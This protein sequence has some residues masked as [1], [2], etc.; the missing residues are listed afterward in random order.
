M[1][2]GI[3]ALFKNFS[4]LDSSSSDMS[5]MGKPSGKG[6]PIVKGVQGLALS[7]FQLFVECVDLLPI[8]KHFLFLLREVGSLG[9]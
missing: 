6:R 1:S 2:S 4:Y 7:E 8:F 5:V 3:I 9:D